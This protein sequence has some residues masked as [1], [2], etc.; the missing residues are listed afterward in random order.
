MRPES[1]PTTPTT[2]RDLHGFVAFVS[3]FCFTRDLLHLPC[4]GPRGYADPLR[5]PFVVWFQRL[6]HARVVWG[7]GA[8]CDFGHDLLDH[9]HCFLKEFVLNVF[10]FFVG[11]KCIVGQDP[12]AILWFIGLSKIMGVD[13]GYW[14]KMVGQHDAQW[15]QFQN[16]S[17]C[18]GWEDPKRADWEPTICKI[19]GPILVISLLYLLRQKAKTSWGEL[20]GCAML[21]C[22]TC[23]VQ[24]FWWAYLIELQRSRSNRFGFM[25]MHHVTYE[26][27]AAPTLGCRTS[28]LQAIEAV[29]SFD[30]FLR[31]E[32]LNHGPKRCLVHGSY[33]SSLNNVSSWCGGCPRMV[34]AHTGRPKY[35]EINT[36][37]RARILQEGMNQHQ[38]IDL[39]NWFF[40][41]WGRLRQERRDDWLT[42]TCRQ[43]YGS[44]HILSQMIWLTIDN[45]A[46]HG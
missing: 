28:C 16:G 2:F 5:W 7:A 25:C 33:Y 27:C 3:D 39:C 18:C 20:H 37:G 13:S 34:Q 10:L 15:P 14:A 11:L 35:I 36:S 40:L 31:N 26:R 44:L 23:Q 17:S 1:I 22:T 30:V 32:W 42:G 29:T 38:Q 6:N 21:H 9:W 43:P 41:Q 12:T 45:Q 46:P 8:G 4:G 19:P 24:H